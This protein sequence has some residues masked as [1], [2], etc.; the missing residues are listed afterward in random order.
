MAMPRID[1][2]PTWNGGPAQWAEMYRGFGL[3]VVPSHKPAPGTQWKRPAI[4][5]WKQFQEELVPQSL[6]E[7]WYA[8][9]G[10]FARHE[11]MGLI[12]GRASGNIFVLDLDT[13][14]GLAANAWWEAQC[15]L[16]NGGQIP[17]SWRSRT[18][19]GGRHLFFKAPE[20]WV[21]PNNNTAIGVDIKGQGG[22]VVLPPSLH[23]DGVYAWELGYAPFE[24]GE[25]EEAPRWLLDAIDDLAE[26]HG[27]HKPETRAADGERVE[28]TP[29]PTG[30]INAFGRRIDGRESAMTKIA[31]HG[32]LEMLRHHSSPTGADIERHRQLAF[33]SYLQS[34][35]TRL[36]GFDNATGLERE[37]RGETLFFAKWDRLL[38]QRGTPKIE[39]MVARPNPKGEARQEAPAPL[40]GAFSFLDLMNRDVV[41][42]PAYIEPDLLSAAGFVV[43]GGP[44]KAQKS[45]LLQ[46]MQI[47]CALGRPFM[48][49]SFTVPRPLRV[50]CLQAEMTEKL[51]RRRAKM[52]RGQYS[53]EEQ[54]L[55]E[56]NLIVSDRFKMVLDDNGVAQA[57]ALIRSCYLPDA[58]PDILSFD[59]LANLYD[60]DSENDSAQ[61]MRFL[62]LRIEAIRR[63]VNPLAGVVLIH[64]ATKVSPEVM[65]RD[66]FSCLRGGGALR[67]YYDSG[68]VIFRKD[69][70]SEEREAHFEMRG[71]ESPEPLLLT[72]KDGRFAKSGTVF[73]GAQ[74]KGWPDAQIQN[75]ILTTIQAAW[76]RGEPWSNQERTR[77]FGRYAP[78]IIH[79]DYPSIAEKT[80][81]EMINSW[82]MPGGVLALAVYNRRMKTLGLCERRYV[83]AGAEISPRI[84]EK[85]G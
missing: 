68:I 15:F 65:R 25:L 30:D 9:D 57:V 59:P 28:T 21:V 48:A 74:R 23:T 1:F 84:A 13:Y 7:R 55:L 31:L 11:N 50:F 85:D 34:T 10:L 38:R 46:E 26:A 78:Q 49:E 3:Q 51:L 29:S 82:L 61:M 67:S 20:T 47:A 73:F 83:P 80:A 44:P 4:K 60:Q 18:G 58:P 14:K 75:A 40:S 52:F 64:H 2:D 43:I 33:N 63:A 6:F 70:D 81:L 8:G 76:N 39:A 45:F 22:F 53:A 19:G 69:A 42:E 36:S 56:Q 35:A 16:N 32:F 66:P 71:G 79:R 54:A 12:T 77:R 27:G 72:F 17:H 24:V 62:M 37:G 5:E 41:E